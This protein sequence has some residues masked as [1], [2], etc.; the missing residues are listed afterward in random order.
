MGYFSE[1]STKYSTSYLHYIDT[2]TISFCLGILLGYGLRV[3]TT[4]SLATR[5]LKGY[6]CTYKEVEKRTILIP[7]HQMSRVRASASSASSSPSSNIP[8]SG[9]KNPFARFIAGLTSRG[10]GTEYQ[11][12][13]FN[14]MEEKEQDE[15]RNKPETAEAECQVCP[16]IISKRERRNV[17]EESSEGFETPREGYI[18][19]MFGGSGESGGACARESVQEQI[20][21]P[22]TTHTCAICFDDDLCL[23]NANTTLT[24]CGHAFHL[25]C[26][27]KSLNAKNLCP[28]CRTPLEDARN[29]QLPENM[30][31]PASAEQ[32]IVEEIS[33]FPNT[34]HAQSISNSSHPRRR[35]KDTLRVFGFALLRSVAGYIHDENMPS[36][37]YDDDESDDDESEDN[38]DGNDNEDNE[39]GNGNDNED[40]HG[41]DNEDEHGNEDNEDDNDDDDNEENELP[42][43]QG[44]IAGSR[45]QTR[46]AALVVLRRLGGGER[47]VHDLRELIGGR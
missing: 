38:E 8:K 39:D 27:L 23:G 28:M 46:S 21:A 42:P 44:Q 16:E 33:Y 22:P 3:F 40:E 10:D 32:M 30:L 24:E 37:W 5:K 12:M 20:P 35:L 14:E 25:S 17:C 15:E 11:E 9:Y 2:N 18:Q 47:E 4:F 31:T 1:Y 34:P 36:E 45:P 13:H 7:Y 19:A 29:K 43:I 41:N 6:N 26:L